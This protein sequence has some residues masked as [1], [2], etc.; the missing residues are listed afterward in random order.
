MKRTLLMLIVGII[1]ALA[2]TGT[3][4][5][6]LSKAEKNLEREA[7]RL[8]D[9]AAKSDGEKA[10]LKRIERE[11][12]VSDAQVQALRDRKLGYGEIAIVLSLAQKMPGGVAEVNVQKVLSL[13]QG[14]P[15]AGWGQVARQLGTKLGA[16][17]SQ[18]KKMNNDS[19]REIKKDHARAGTAGKKTQQEPPQEKKE[20]EP[21]RDFKGEGRP[22]NR[23]GG[24][25]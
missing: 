8:N 10:V 25:M 3:A 7:K 1:A 6:E 5:A 14:P 12:K 17:V 2:G 23:G 19:N 21:P 9:T 16:T 13:R 22:M 15:A 24:A 18:V 4:W 11:F 20:P